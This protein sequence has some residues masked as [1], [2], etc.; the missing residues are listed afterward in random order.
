MAVIGIGV[1]PSAFSYQLEYFTASEQQTKNKKKRANV[2]KKKHIIIGCGTA[3]LTALKRM[4]QNNTGDQIRIVSM[5]P[6][7]PYS[8]TSL[9]YVI[10]GRIPES[11]ISM[12]TG[13]FFERM[14]AAWV[15]NSRVEHVDAKKGEIVYASGG[16]E[17]YDS[18]LIATGS[19]PLLPAIPG[20][21]TSG[22]VQLRTL[23]DARGIAGKIK[24]GGSAII[25][26]AGLIGMHVAQCLAETGM[27]VKVVEM[28]PRILSAYFDEEA[29]S[30]IQ[31]VLEERGISFFTGSQAVEVSSGKNSVNVLLQGG[32]RLEG[33]LLIVAAG[34]SPRASMVS[35]SGVNVHNGILVDKQMK[36]NIPN[37]FAAGDVAEAVNFFTGEHGLNPILPSA[38]EQ[39]NV[40]GSNMAGDEKEY[41]GWL[42][43]NTFN[44]FGRRAVSVGQTMPAAGD[45]V[46]SQK[47]GD[48]S[49]KR[50]ICRHGKL[51]GAA[52]LSTD[53]DAGVFQYLVRKRVETDPQKHLLLERP[54]ETSLW[55]MREAEKR[56]TFTI[57]D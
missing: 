31:Q 11:E 35:G 46:L 56:E 8:P 48:R 39:G 33:Q 12:V 50:L 43:M 13:D 34:V 23:D 44:F 14:N 29:S 49:Y 21:N 45:E 28:L 16:R 1:Q 41:Q 6:H 2:E 5:E 17:A 53:V 27:Q 32:T 54:R 22:A 9:P 19:E 7:L 47:N 30:I 55:L 40:A 42:P 25:I 51:V 38:S 4:R 20:L 52:F 36:T 18:L 3:A 15:R 24:A 26:G 37:I 57:E 10:S